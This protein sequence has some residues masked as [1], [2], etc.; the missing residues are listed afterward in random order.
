MKLTDYMEWKGMSTDDVARRSGV[1]RSTLFKILRGD[2]RP[3]WRTC[4]RISAVTEGCVEPEVIA[5]EYCRADGST[6][7]PPG[8]AA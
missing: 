5:R 4:E 1:H 7:E 6:V 8:E 3:S 2:I